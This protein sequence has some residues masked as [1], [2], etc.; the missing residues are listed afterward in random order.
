MILKKLHIFLFNMVL[1]NLPIGL[2]K[3]FVFNRSYVNGLLVNYLIPTVYVLDV[4]ILLVLFFWFLDKF[5]TPKFRYLRFDSVFT[6][7]IL[8]FFVSFL[9]SSVLAIRVYPAFIG[10]LRWVVYGLF[11]LYILEE[12]DIKVRLKNIFKWISFGVLTVSL[13]GITQSVKQTSLF[14]NYLFFGEQ[15]YSINSL[16]I[17]KENFFGRYVVPSYGTFLHPNIFGGFLSITLIWLLTLKKK[18]HKSVFFVGTVALLTTLSFFS[19]VAFVVGLAALKSEKLAV[20]FTAALFLVGL[21][22]PVLGTQNVYK[23]T[24]S[25]YR[26]GDLETKAYEVI[27]TKYMY[28]VGLSNFTVLSESP[29]GFNQPVH[30]IFLLFIAETGFFPLVFVVLIFLY[31]AKKSNIFCAT[32]STLRLRADNK[33]ILLEKEDLILFLL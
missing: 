8:L 30:N 14:N 1:L 26:R 13:L 24:S 33:K 20:C 22:L 32:K 3:H 21:L 25:L 29:F 23:N 28:G 19:W 5:V 16:G 12:V 11:G 10:L 7:F 6:V 2:A 17:D 18:I 15:P 9:F 31:L 4:L 27:S